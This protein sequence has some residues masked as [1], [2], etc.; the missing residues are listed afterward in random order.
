MCTY[1]RTETQDVAQN[2][3]DDFFDCKEKKGEK[4]MWVQNGFLKKRKPCMQNLTKEQKLPPVVILQQAIFDIIFIRCLWLR[5]IRSPIKV[6]NSWIFIHRYL[7][8][9]LIMVTEQLYWRKVLCDCSSI[10]WLWL[11]IVIMKR[12][13]ERCELQ[14]H[15]TSLT[16]R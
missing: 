16:K 13:A 4:S 15:R 10:I 11:L 3:I 8:T 6:F 9:M 14:L 2:L 7:L 1:F 12:W 5:I